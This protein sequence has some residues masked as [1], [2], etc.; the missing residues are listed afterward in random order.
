[1]C[2][3]PIPIRN[4][5]YRPLSILSGVSPS[6]EKISHVFT[7]SLQFV[8]KS[9]K[10]L[11]TFHDFLGKYRDTH[12]FYMYVPCGSCKSCIRAKQMSISQRAEMESLNSYCYFITLTY[13]NEHLPLYTEH[14]LQIP[15]ANREHVKNLFKRIRNR[16]VIDRPMRY[17][18]ISERGSSKSR[19]HHHL[20]V[21][22]PK[23]STDNYWTPFQY[24][25]LLYWTFRNEW[26]VNISSDWRHPIYEPLFTYHKKKVGGKWYYNYDCHYIQPHLAD[27]T[28]SVSFYITKYVTKSNRYEKRIKATLKT[29]FADEPALFDSVWRT[30]RS[31][32]TASRNFG[33]KSDDPSEP[34]LDV[35]EHIKKCLDSCDDGIPKYFSPYSGE[36]SGLSPYYCRKSLFMSAERY[37]KYLDA[38]YKAGYYMYGDDR[39]P[40]PRE[41]DNINNILD[42]E[43]RFQN[44][45]NQLDNDT[46]TL[47]DLL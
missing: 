26:R 40:S 5:F 11:S 33:L 25:E 27:V 38:L 39:T 13:N 20:L 14:N 17:L 12:S 3:S 28:E 42:N 41:P 36:F 2:T 47:V 46:C 7:S 37:E 32:M 31:T 29:M 8:T 21:F 23:W 4:P 1:M 30:V 10:N 15:Y 24:E 16:H 19:P 6:G 45:L 18:H 22:L 35:A 9:G 44:T 34:S 43:K